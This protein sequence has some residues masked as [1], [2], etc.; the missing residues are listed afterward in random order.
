MRHTDSHRQDQARL[1]EPG[2]E[3]PGVA[4]RDGML[5]VALP[6]DLPTLFCE[7]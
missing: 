4:E 5:I 1:Q 7:F 6:A 3:A 2:P